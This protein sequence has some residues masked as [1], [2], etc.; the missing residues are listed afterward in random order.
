MSCF[1]A[2]ILS[3]N[4]YNSYYFLSERTYVYIVYVDIYYLKSRLFF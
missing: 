2:S 4:I 3:D 1:H